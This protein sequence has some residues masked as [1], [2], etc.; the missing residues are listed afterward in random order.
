MRKFVCWLWDTAVITR[1]EKDFIWFTTGVNLD[2]IGRKH[3]NGKM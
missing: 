2:H 1:R 3:I